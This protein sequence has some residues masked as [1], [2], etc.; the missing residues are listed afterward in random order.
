MFD[1]VI[2]E[3]AADEVGALDRAGV[4][5][6]MAQG[7]RLHGA[8]TAWMGRLSRRADGLDD[9]GLDGAAMLRVEGR[10]S[11]RSAAAAARVAHAIEELPG[12]AS[13]LQEGRITPEHARTIAE[14]ALKTSPDRADAELV[15]GAELAPADVFAKRTRRWVGRQ[16]TDEEL[17]AAH[18]R[19]R[20]R[21]AGRLWKRHDGTRVL[22]V[23][24]DPVTGNEV[25]SHLGE[26]C[27][28]AWRDDGGRD[29]DP[30]AVRTRE[31][32]L[33]DVVAH[34]LMGRRGRSSAAPPHPR[35]QLTAIFDTTRTG[36]H[37][38]EAA[39]LPDGTPLP[40]AVL[41]RMACDAVITGVVFDGPGR[42][43][44]VGRDHRTATIAQWKAL[45]ARDGGCVGCGAEPGRCEAHHIIAWQVGGPTDI[46]NLVLVCSRCHHDL[47]DR[48]L[49]LMQTPTG[50]TIQPRAGPVAA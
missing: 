42:P 7:R 47:H 48:G 29:G 13:A 26:A 45:I 50:W 49:N 2:A 39:H 5:D 24:F 10:M 33:A 37:P 12:T 35:Y 3:L 17:A 25:E 8:L 23:E 21:R 20:E 40:R 15:P 46:T 14:A 11:S 31:Q 18:E 43:I 41:E 34:E 30:D 16:Q 28:K 4:A 36:E 1:M 9:G 27:E 32:R 19:A 44:W 6:R 22:H 38:A